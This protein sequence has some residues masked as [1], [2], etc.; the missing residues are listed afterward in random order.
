MIPFPNVNKVGLLINSYGPYRGNLNSVGLSGREKGIVCIDW[1]FL[2]IAATAPGTGS[3]AVDD[4][5][6]EKLSTTEKIKHVFKS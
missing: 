3:V 6:H 5:Q 2:R 4:N 1:S